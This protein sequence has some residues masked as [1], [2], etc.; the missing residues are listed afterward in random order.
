LARGG[1]LPNPKPNAESWISNRLIIMKIQIKF[2][3][4]SEEP[5][6]KFTQGQILDVILIEGDE[7]GTIFQIEGIEGE[8]HLPKNLYQWA[9]IH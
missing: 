3:I 8:I 1:L 7:Q 5:K 2:D 9:E 6:Y 4:E